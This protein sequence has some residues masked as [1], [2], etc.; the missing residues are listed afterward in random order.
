M[1]EGVEKEDR[2]RFALGAYNIGLGHIEDA[3][4]LAGSRG[5]DPNRWASLV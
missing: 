2:L 3:R 4:R 5:L 1:F